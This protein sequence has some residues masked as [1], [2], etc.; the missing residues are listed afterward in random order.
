MARF[1]S[2]E[3]FDQLEVAGYVAL[4]GAPAGQLVVEVLVA[5]APGGAVRYQVVLD[6]GHGLVLGPTQAERA[7][8]VRLD[9]DYATLAGLASGSM[10]A[11]E[12]LS[13]GGARL[14]GDIAA[15]NGAGRRLGAL[16]LV[17][18]AL[19]ASTSF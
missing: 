18:A 5:D 14:S 3:W 7:A 8:Q 1:L 13:T 17:P 15:L 6:D 2:L 4:E 19:R 16:D 10:S 12:A 9:S 11:L